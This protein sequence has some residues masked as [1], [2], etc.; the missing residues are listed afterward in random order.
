MEGGVQFQ[1]QLVF[2]G[3]GRYRKDGGRGKG[4]TEWQ[5]KGRRDQTTYNDSPGREKE[6][7]G[8]VEGEMEPQNPQHQYKERNQEEERRDLKGGNPQQRRGGGGEHREP[9]DT[10]CCVQMD[11]EA[12]SARG[13][14]R[15]KALWEE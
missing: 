10:Q 6:G 11:E 15:R 14:S 12:Q 4:D 8:A 7:K 3:P 9:C 5:E 1:E 2:R 13:R